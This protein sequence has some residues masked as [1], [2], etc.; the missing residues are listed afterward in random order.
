[1]FRS[2]ILISALD[3]SPS[4]TYALPFYLK[5]A[6][7]LPVL[8][9]CTLDHLPLENAQAG[10]SRGRCRPGSNWRYA[11]EAETE[12]KGSAETGMCFSTYTYGSGDTAVEV[13]IAIPE[14]ATSDGPYD[15]LLS[16]VAPVDLGWVG[17]SWGGSTTYVPLSVAWP[18]G[19]EVMVNARMAYGY[20]VPAP[21]EDATHTVLENSF[22]N[23]T[24]WSLDAVC[25]GRA[26]WEDFDGNLQV[27][28]TEE[29]VYLA[30]AASYSPVDGPDNEETTFSI[31]SP[32]AH[33]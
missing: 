31:H 30:L 9:F 16:I 24:H 14:S 7:M 10:L 8:A 23:D 33:W 1:M 6:L 12:K 27:L 11:Q 29:P 18:N 2:R 4:P 17:V 3:S 15:V 25:T 19:D 20:Y 26:A 13:G 21:Y 28:S 22:V 32:T 5:P